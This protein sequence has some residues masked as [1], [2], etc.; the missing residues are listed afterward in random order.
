MGH[1]HHHHSGHDHHHEDSTKNIRFAFFLNLIFTI[2]EII[3]G[4]YT[5]SVAILSDAL[6]DLG[7]SI[8][9]GLSW[10]FDKV[11]KKKRDLNY[12][13]GYGRFSLLAAFINSVV[14]ITGSLVILI[15]A[16]PRLVNPEQPDAQGMII[17]SIFG[18]LFNGAA[19]LK[20]KNGKSMNEKV[21]TLH[22]LEDVFG[23]VTVLIAS[24]VMYFWYFPIL[25]PLLSLLFTSYILFNVIKNFKQTIRIFLQGKPENIDL[26]VFKDSLMRID[27]LNSVHDLHVW[28]MDGAFYVMTLHMVVDDDIDNQEILNIKNKIREISNSNNIQHI[29]IEVE[30]ESENCT[31]EKC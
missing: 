22:L 3:G 25:D 12:T 7:D 14:L 27:G 10:Y 31:L 8:S 6:H 9:L 17:L 1:L 29:T 21:V 28:T 18:V 20:V 2:I 4:I 30:F 13:Y 23:W 24:I 15:I 16:L 5:N 11:S 26:Q 19:V